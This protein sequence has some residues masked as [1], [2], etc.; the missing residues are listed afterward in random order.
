MHVEETK[1]DGVK[2]ITPAKI[3]DDRGWFA[4]MYNAR[5]FEEAGLPLHFVQDNQS[6]SKRG[7]LR[8]LHYQVGKPQG[9][10]VRVVEGEV[11]DIAVDIR[12]KST[13]FGQWFGVN[14]TAELGNML[15]IPVGFAHGFLVLSDRAQVLYKV[16]DYY[17]PEGDRAIKWD[18]PQ[19]GIK[20][21]LDA[22][23]PME[24]ILSEKDLAAKPLDEADKF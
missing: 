14:L 10:L 19:I 9:K 2:V 4:E 17:Y 23:K 12:E 21:P 3:G 22:I 5:K 7:V 6:M 13:T 20:W 18:D 8:G 1:L 15:W 24:P 11:F 16:T